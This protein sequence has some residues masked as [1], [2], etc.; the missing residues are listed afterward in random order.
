MAATSSSHFAPETRTL[1]ITRVFNA[2]R[3][4]VFKAWTDPKQMAVWWGPKDFTNPVC[5]VDARQGGAI[6]IHMKGPDGTV[7]P[8]HGSFREVKAPERLVFV[9]TA[10]DEGDDPGFEI[11]NTVVFTEQGGRTRIDLQAVIIR[12][13]PTSAGALAGMEAGW[14]Q[15]LDRLTAFVEPPATA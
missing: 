9:C 3:D 4:L 13:S 6:R 14:N 7:Y 10:H 11:V 2:P 15:S 5:E 1:T 8:M 12:S